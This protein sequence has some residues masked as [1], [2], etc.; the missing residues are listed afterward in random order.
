MKKFFKIVLI[1]I[2][3]L[4]GLS[5]VMWYKG[6]QSFRLRDVELLIE[7]PQEIQ[8]GEEIIYN[9]KY[10][11]K[12]KVSLLNTK[13]FFDSQQIKD[14]GELA[15][16]DQGQVEINR[17]ISGE[18]GQLIEAEA[19]LTYKPSNLNS[20]FVSVKKTSFII[21]EPGVMLSIEAPQEAIN[22][23]L[24]NY[25][26]NYLN[27]SDQEINDLILYIE[28]PSGFEPET[29]KSEYVLKS[30][31]PDQIKHLKISGV[32]KGNE[33]EVK[34][35]RA[36]INQVNWVSADVAIVGPPLEI[37][38]N[39]SNNK[40]V[41]DYNNTSDIVLSDVKFNLEFTY[42][43]DIFAWDNVRAEKGS[44]D[45]FAKIAVWVSSGVSKLAEINPGDQGQLVLNLPFKGDLSQTEEVE[46][47]T[48][49]NVLSSEFNTTQE[50]EFKIPTVINLQA[51]AD[52][53]GGTLPPKVGKTTY[54]NIYWRVMNSFNQ[55]DNVM[56]TAS[57]PAN[58]AWNNLISLEKGDLRWD[59][60]NKEVVWDLGNLP[61]QTGYNSPVQEAV[62]QVA[63]TPDITQAGNSVWIL[64]ETIL[65]AI[66]SFTQDSI[67]ANQSFITSDLTDDP[68]LSP[69]DGIVGN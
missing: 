21:G 49:L 19:K 62:F 15:P 12:T 33:G 69:G 42:V 64:G 28:F 35:L 27:K 39:Y 29:E 47:K 37:S 22:G 30:I 65:S 46:L 4:A 68:N 3:F 41:I 10:H 9:V 54:Y 53:S 1:L 11:N 16:G 25:N 7:H 36:R 6:Q 60:E 24:I 55:A 58:V 2:V 61:A 31:K 38:Q 26:F 34:T 14:L 32:I 50:A 51:S 13:L 59:E 17:K 20:P 40:I 45:K 5:G 23:Q 56:I 57:L 52:Y 66:D 48:K 18:P 63:L 44:F 8:S 67:T 43:P